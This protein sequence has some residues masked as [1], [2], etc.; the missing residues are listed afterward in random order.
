VCGHLKRMNL[1]D[2]VR[3]VNAARQQRQEGQVA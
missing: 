2:V 3:A 1:L